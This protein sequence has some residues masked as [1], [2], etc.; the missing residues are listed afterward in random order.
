VS[1]EASAVPPSRALLELLPAAALAVPALA[2]LTWMQGPAAV[3]G[4]YAFLCL[5]AGFVLLA[6]RRAIRPLGFLDLPARAALLA[7]ALILAA[8]FLNDLA[9][10]LV[11]DYLYALSAPFQRNP[12]EGR[13]AAKAWLLASGENIYSGLDGF[14]YLITLYGPV[15]YVLAALFAKIA[16]PGLASARAVSMCGAAL[17]LFAAYKLVSLQGGR[18]AAVIAAALLLISPLMEYGFFARPDILAWSFVFTAAWLLQAALSKESGGARLVIAAAALMVL[19]V[20]TKQQTWAFCLASMMYLLLARRFRVFFRFSAALCL[21]GLAA[22]ALLLALTDGRFFLQNVWFPKLMAGLT[23]MNKDEFA[24]AR[25]KVYFSANGVLLALYACNLICNVRKRKL[26]LLD[27][28]FFTFL[29]FLYVVLRWTGA[30]YNHF[31]SLDIIMRL[32]AGCLLGRF[33]GLGAAGFGAALAAM[34]LLV[35]IKTDFLANLQNNAKNQAAALSD[36]NALDALFT[37]AANASDGKGEIL[38]NAEAAYLGLGRP[39]FRAFRIFDAFE[40]DIYE[41]VGLWTLADSDLAKGIRDRRFSLAVISPTF[42]PR[43]VTSLLR[44]YYRPEGEIRGLSLFK[45]RSERAILSFPNAD[46]S[47][48]EASGVSARIANVENLK[49]EADMITSDGL[50]RPGEIVFEVESGGS[51]ALPGLILSPR[52]NRSDPTARMEILASLDG[53]PYERLWSWEG[54]RGEEGWSPMWDRRVAVRAAQASKR[55]RLKVILQGPAQ[56]LFDADHPMLVT[57]DAP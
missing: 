31:L 8:G 21:F 53:G 10:V 45:P 14:P 12:M 17:L 38:I 40:A 26:W 24:L 2:L 27:V 28:M 5:G 42:Q 44:D 3:S 30:E 51:P 9:N 52:L 48:R 25:L 49:R 11:N 20:Y 22:L 7:A 32:A 41:Q 55:V 16:G 33:L 4:K 15:Y 1:P 54:G 34:L 50:D 47:E 36:R 37:D 39:F 18:R 29:P 19:A 23:G 35:P 57:A 43:T 13:D 46:A 56:L 6:A